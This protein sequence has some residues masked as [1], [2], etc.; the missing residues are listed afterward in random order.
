MTENESAMK[1]LT[2]EELLDSSLGRIMFSLGMEVMNAGLKRDADKLKKIQ[3]V[4][5]ALSDLWP[6]E[7]ENIHSTIADAEERDDS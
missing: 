6:K 5:A 4:H 7:V 3:A 1:D 2:E